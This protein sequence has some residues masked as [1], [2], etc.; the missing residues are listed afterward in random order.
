MARTWSPLAPCATVITS[1]PQVSG[2]TM[3]SLS[4][5]LALWND[6]TALSV[7]GP[8]SPSAAMPE[9]RWRSR[10]CTVVTVTPDWPVCTCGQAGGAADAGVPGTSA[11]ATPMNVAATEPAMLRS[12]LLAMW[13]L[14]RSGGWLGLAQGFL[15]RI[16]RPRK[17]STTILKVPLYVA[18]VLQFGE[19]RC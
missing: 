3:P 17:I 11:T 9:P 2:P 4:S 6:L 14:P 8:K 7:A 16:H 12:R 15:P 10:S 18:R 5:P 19:Y 13:F 1:L